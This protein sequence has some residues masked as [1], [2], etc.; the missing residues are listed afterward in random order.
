MDLISNMFAH[1]RNAIKLNA[2][3]VNIPYSKIN[4]KL[5]QIFQTEGFILGYEVSNI[6]YVTVFLKYLSTGSVI[7]ELKRISKPS[8]RIYMRSKQ[9]YLIN[10]GFSFYI[11]S[12]PLG[13]MTNIKAKLSNVGGEV[14]CKIN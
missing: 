1:I 5:L 14:I 12:T 7:K 11:L 6:R 9:N 3:T 10:N 8:K 4:I 13:L 2:L